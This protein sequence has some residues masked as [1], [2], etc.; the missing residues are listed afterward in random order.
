MKIYTRRGDRGETDL[1]AGGRVRKDHLR[2]ESCH[3]RVAERLD[4]PIRETHQRFAVAD[5]RYCEGRT[6]DHCQGEAG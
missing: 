5:V 6:L 3:G 1:F 2:V 4:G